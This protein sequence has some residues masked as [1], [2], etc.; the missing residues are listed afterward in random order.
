MHTDGDALQRSIDEY[1]LGCYL[2]E[3]PPRIDELAQVLR[4]HPV[5]VRRRAQR[6][7][8]I[9]VARYMKAAQLRFACE[10]LAHGLAI[11]E[12]ARQ[13]AFGSR[14]SFLRSF[15]RELRQTPDAFRRE[16]GQT[17]DAFRRE[18][19]TP[20]AFRCELGTPDASQYENVTRRNQPF[21]RD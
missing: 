3:S 5:V 2:R 21:S 16:L 7:F 6:R 15:R 4:L 19:G 20:D 9:S 8:G 17:P 13:A 11:G 14:R 12:V 18:L 10:L 1:L